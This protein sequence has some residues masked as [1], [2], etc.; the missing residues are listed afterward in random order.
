MLFRVL[1]PLEVLGEGGQSIPVNGPRL[2]RLLAILVLRANHDVSTDQLV[3]GLWGDKPPAG[4]VN[5]IQVQVSKL[6]R[7]LSADGEPSPVRTTSSGY[8]L[9]ALAGSTDVGRFQELVAQGRAHAAAG[10]L[11]QGAASLAQALALWRGELLADF[12]FDEFTQAA[13]LR[14][15][16]E[17]LVCLEERI[18]LDLALGGD[19]ELVPELEAVAAE[20]PLREHICG[21]LM[22]ALY[23]SG[24]QAE[25]LRAFRRTHDLLVEELGVGPG[26]QLTGLEQRM[27]NQDPSLLL[28]AT[29]SP[30][31]GAELADHHQASD[32][33]ER[34]APTPTPTPTPSDGPT[35][36]DRDGA[37]PRSH[38]GPRL[39]P[40]LS[41]CLGRDHDI[42]L[43]TSR[44]ASRR[45]VTV[46][47]PGGVGKTRL[48]VEVASGPADGW[49]GGVWM[50][51][52]GSSEGPDA[53]AEALARTFSGWLQASPGGPAQ[54]ASIVDLVAAA[55]GSSEL[56][57]VV[58]NCEHVVDQ[59]AEAIAT[60][61]RA[62]PRLTILATSRE[63]LGTP[64]EVIHQLQPLS[65]TM[66]VELFVA[67]A[68]EASTRFVADD[69]TLTAIAQI[70]DHLDR[71]P[72]AIE[73]AAARTRAF[74]VDQLAHRLGDRFG[75]VA[76]TSADRPARHHT[77]HAAV[78][79][80]F[81]LLFEDERLLLT[82][83]AVFAGGFTLEAA[84][85]VAADD[86]Q[87][88]A[89]DLADVLAR[90]VDK[91]LV[92]RDPPGP[93]PAA[94]R[95]R[96]LQAVA[97]FALERLD[98]ESRHAAVRDRHLRWL[99]ELT[100]G[101]TAGLRGA[102][103]RRWLQ[104]LSDEERNLGRGAHWTF[105]GGD[106]ALG[107]RIV[108]NLG[109]YVFVT[110]R[111]TDYHDMGLRVLAAAPTAP[112]PLRT[113]VKGYAG[114]LS[115]GRSTAS[116]EGGATDRTLAAQALDEA[117]ALG[118]P[119]L[120][121]EMAM[122]R[123]LPLALT[124]GW[125]AQAQDLL[126]EARAAM[127]P[128]R[129]PWVEAFVV[130][131]EGATRFLSGEPAAAVVLLSQASAG[132][133]NL[134]D[135]LTAALVDIRR[136]EAA[137]LIGDIDGAV[138]AIDAVLDHAQDD[139]PRSP[140]T[141]MMAAR[142][143][144]F[145]LR[146]GDHQQALAQ[147]LQAEIPAGQPCHRA[148]RAGSALVLGAAYG[149]NGQFEL[150]YQQLRPAIE[151][152]QQFEFRRESAVAHSELGRAQLLGGRP[153]QALGS[154]RRAVGLA[155]DC[156]LP[157]VLISCLDGLAEALADQGHHEE[158]ARIL[159]A[160]AALVVRVGAGGTAAEQ[161]AR[162]SVRAAIAAA[163][164]PEPTAGSEAV[165]AGLDN[166]QL[167]ALVDANSVDANSVDAGPIGAEPVEPGGPPTA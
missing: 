129:D 29:P 163:I 91:S 17:R 161:A 138:D 33:L 15:S 97:D 134:G 76:S 23:R 145:T 101:V 74:T 82:H 90:L 81:D 158:A 13:R 155:L 114:L 50:V 147:A 96:L 100:D 149:R 32:A 112:A 108:A 70:C 160:S 87:L 79:W 85:A 143:A 38:P 69:H 122:L 83:L 102:D 133:R 43:V 139:E 126:D 64:G 46:I 65:A 89:A 27:L 4:A 88:P 36:A 1:G 21:Q 120:L 146:R 131:L 47:G 109:W 141:L 6:R 107:L 66:A 34:D 137:E 151:F 67:R 95:Y 2:R 115:F 105:G 127:G 167:G 128:G 5:A 118:D 94:P 121:A 20:H 44:L 42:E 116:A 156:G 104:V 68:S 119:G 58:D 30:V 37:G 113:R 125:G 8:V 106:P 132:F 93:G 49:P 59:A 56:L 16:Q 57:V 153:D 124:P 92:I 24:R 39:A 111:L 52:L 45:V 164:G 150:A 123:A 159:G 11:E 135:D 9:D 166:R 25:A 18:D 26:P 71:L 80:S 75:V 103:Q 12:A 99:A 14:L 31:V 53:V 54:P 62:C 48:A 98:Q 162:A 157:T 148:V 3:D 78:E 60:L 55:I 154:H 140:I 84:E 19:S 77:L 28:P 22:T 61:L 63:P 136:S 110:S 130:G 117:R 165:G 73:L 41:D 142:R 51:E 86:G 7:V 10:R 35:P 144:W 40:A 152:F 72:L